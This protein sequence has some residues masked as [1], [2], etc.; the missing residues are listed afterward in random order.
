M[1]TPYLVLTTTALDF[2]LTYLGDCNI[3]A[4]TLVVVPFRSQRLVGV[5]FS[6]DITTSFTGKIKSIEATLPYNITQNFISFIKQASTYTMIPMGHIL[7]MSIMLKC[8]ALDKSEKSLPSPTYILDRL[9]LNADQQTAFNICN[10]SLNQFNTLAL[11]GV[12]GSGKTELYFSVI[13]SALKMEKKAL[14]LFPEIAL[15]EAIVNRF[16]DTFGQA[17]LIW[18]SDV[19]PAQK[20]KIWK[21]LQTNDP[22]VIL[23][24]RSALFLPIK[25]LGLIVIDEEH[26]TSYK[27]EEQGYYNARDMAILRAKHED[28]PI[29]LTSATPS[30]ETYINIKNKR[31]THLTLG[32]R[33]GAAEMPEVRIIDQK[34]YPKSIITDPIQYEVRKRLTQKEQSLLFLNRRG[35]S[36][37]LA[38][39]SCGHHFECPGCHALLTWHK[40]KQIMQC[41]YCG[42]HAQK[43]SCCPKCTNT[44]LKD[45]GLGVEKV[46]EEAKRL[47]PNARIC[48]ISS[49]T[50]ANPATSKQLLNDVEAGIFDIIIGTQVLAKGHH[51][52]N[53][54]FVGVLDADRSLRMMDLRA[55]EKT[56]QLLS[57]VG[58]RAGRMARKPGLVIL[59]TR[60]PEHP[61]FKALKA[62]DRD[63]FY[64]TELEE[65]KM[66]AMPPFY[67]LISI[68]VSSLRED[69]LQE[70]CRQLSY[71]I[72]HTDDIDVLG[73][74]PSALYRL[75]SRYRMR[76][77]IK[78]DRKQNLQAFTKA[79]L[80]EV[81][82]PNAVQLHV[83]VD[84]LNFM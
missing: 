84:P 24:A 1:H 65:R 21:Q 3:P 5:V 43:P 69:I 48:I 71:H 7:K 72:P 26:D 31:Y 68:T 60:E 70:T 6:Q 51:F 53:L 14:V 37:M 8:D 59:Q 39:F 11:D 50:L 29:I 79:W 27:Q 47:F 63:V 78:G 74:A 58:G 41:H 30:L 67:R 20:R 28:I 82:L 77:L 4:G 83:D 15:T 45:L 49:D 12:T 61:L 75:R 33:Y 13:Q 18:H 42:F 57:Q 19:T 73:P 46:E 9:V 2:P 34:E 66:L 64:E 23:G 76:F 44:Q 22:L 40:E 25:N 62:Y 52:P 16:K 54:T 32:K 38:C 17:P 36:S 35:F 55:A 81:K 80:S 56:F 10:A